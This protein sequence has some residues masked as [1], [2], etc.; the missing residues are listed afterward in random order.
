M[1]GGFRRKTTWNLQGSGVANMQSSPICTQR[2]TK[3]GSRESTGFPLKHEP[4]MPSSFK[5]WHFLEVPFP[6][7]STRAWQ[8][9]GIWGVC[10]AAGSLSGGPHSWTNEGQ[11]EAGNLAQGSL[12][13]RSQYLATPIALALSN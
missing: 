5:A 7:V 8:P 2:R 9:K 11:P 13:L 12:D 3:A 4:S 10:W 6:H 1:P